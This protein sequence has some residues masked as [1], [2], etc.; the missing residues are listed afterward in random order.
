MGNVK[1]DLLVTSTFCDIASRTSEAK[2]E[3]NGVAKISALGGCHSRVSNQLA[4]SCIRGP[5]GS[6]RTQ[7]HVGICPNKAAM[8]CSERLEYELR[9]VRSLIDWLTRWPA[10]K[11][12]S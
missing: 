6:H 8:P 7:I 9:A 2:Y 10:G 1:F 12:A 11:I 3:Y 4:D 5:R